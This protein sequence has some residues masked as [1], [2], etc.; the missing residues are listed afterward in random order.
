MKHLFAQLVKF[1]IV[2]VVATGIDFAVLFVLHQLFGLDSVVASVISFVVSLIFNYVAS[3]HYVFERRSDISRTHE[4]VL[5]VVLSLVGLALNSG[6]MYAG[7]AI[8]VA[9]GVAYEQSQYYLLV[10]VFATAVVMGWNFVS[11]KLWLDAGKEA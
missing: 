5:F 3:M 10:K 1:G 4:F 8:F 6:L 7:R 2:G 11:R 9:R